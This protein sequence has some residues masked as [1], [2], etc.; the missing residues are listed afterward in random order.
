MEGSREVTL[1]LP[2]KEYEEYRKQ[3]S[4]EYS[5]N[6]ASNI[7]RLKGTHKKLGVIYAK[8]KN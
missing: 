1:V 2:G 7:K 5:Y 8:S 3:Q 6:F 4:K